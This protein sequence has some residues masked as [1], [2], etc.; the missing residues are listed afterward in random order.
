[1]HTWV[2]LLQRLKFRLRPFQAH[3]SRRH[4]H[5]RALPGATSATAPSNSR[6]GQPTPST[7]APEPAR[8]LSLAAAALTLSSAAAAGADEAVADAAQQVQRSSGGLLGPISDGLESVLKLLQTGL[9]TIHVP[10]S[11][12]WSIIMLTLL[13]KV[14]TYPFLKKQV[15]HPPCAAMH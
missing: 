13:V 6:Q 8:L 5:I 3:S 11:Y 4:A 15:C 12:G 9:D 14:A 1:M 7:S 10:Y 2:V